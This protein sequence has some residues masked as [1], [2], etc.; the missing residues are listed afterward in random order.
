MATDAG[1]SLDEFKE[2]LVD[3]YN[4]V[5]NL[6]ETGEAHP[7]QPLS[8]G[9]L[10]LHQGISQFLK[11]GFYPRGNCKFY[12]FQTAGSSKS[13]W[14]ALLEGLVGQE[15]SAAIETGALGGEHTLATFVGKL[16]LVAHDITVDLSGRAVG[17]PRGNNAPIQP[18]GNLHH[19]LYSP[20][21]EVVADYLAK[22]LRHLPSSWTA[23]RGRRRTSDAGKPVFAAA[24]FSVI[25]QD[26]LGF[27]EEHHLPKT[28]KK[29]TRSVSE[30]VNESLTKES[31]ALLAYFSERDFFNLVIEYCGNSRAMKKS[32]FPHLWEEEP[33][34]QVLGTHPQNTQAIKGLVFMDSPAYTNLIQGGGLLFNEDYL[35]IEATPSNDFSPVLPLFQ[36]LPFWRYPLRS[37][38]VE[39]AQKQT[40]EGFV[41]RGANSPPGWLFT[42]NDV[43]AHLRGVVHSFQGLQLL[44]CQQPAEAEE[45]LKNEQLLRTYLQT[46]LLQT[47]PSLGLSPNTGGTLVEGL[48]RE[49]FS[50]SSG[51]ME[52]VFPD[53]PHWV[54][55]NEVAFP[56][57]TLHE[58]TYTS[59]LKEIK[60]PIFF[61]LA[62]SLMETGGYLSAC[63]LFW[64]ADKLGVEYPDLNLNFST[65][66][67][68][69]LYRVGYSYEVGAL[70]NLFAP[71]PEQEGSQWSFFTLYNDARE[72]QPEQDL[73]KRPADKVQ[74]LVSAIQARLTALKKIVNFEL[75]EEDKSSFFSSFEQQVKLGKTPGPE[76]ETADAKLGVLGPVVS[77]QE[78]LSFSSNFF[79]SAVEQLEKAAAKPPAPE[80]LD[81]QTEGPTSGDVETVSQVVDA[82]LSDNEGPMDQVF[83]PKNRGKALVL[84]GRV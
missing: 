16:L 22:R 50:F 14:V 40:G 73:S 82:Q 35:K 4:K 57:E 46:F 27:L 52:K 36:T 15:A 80:T 19:F 20:P 34:A 63:R 70:E 56:E 48:P 42:R 62:G 54:R 39:M 3:I 79:D 58:T 59:H 76:T 45:L 41:D 49:F 67:P 31:K 23:G 21:Y 74:V 60:E 69:E 11:R 1:F 5:E 77:P 43:F 68:P 38:N 32:R 7:Y 53:Y 8:L 2:L 64:E 28:S 17:H 71:Y 10:T 29:F 24:M 51:F 65:L 18:R 6:G 30:A 25:Y 26:F 55:D 47:N 84:K 61:T 33:L 44:E 12:C 83:F 78:T 37:L 72:F 9:Y 13:S 81:T 66:N 75:L